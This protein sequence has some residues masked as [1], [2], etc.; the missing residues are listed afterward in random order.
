METFFCRTVCVL[1]VK[2]RARLFQWS[3]FLKKNKTKKNTLA[4]LFVIACIL[5]FLFDYQ[6]F[7]YVKPLSILCT[8]PSPLTPLQH[9][10]PKIHAESTGSHQSS[11]RYLLSVSRGAASTI[12]PVH[13]K[14]HSE[15]QY[16]RNHRNSPVFVSSAG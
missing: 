13:V 5:S 6:H 9:L 3:L 15:P 16:V 4:R 8:Q 11:P 2:G 10:D 7:R 14:F 1:C 12:S